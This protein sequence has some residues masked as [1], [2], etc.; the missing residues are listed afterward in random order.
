MEEEKKLP[1]N[2]RQMAEKEE[3]VRVYLEDYAYTFIHKLNCD[4]RVRTGV[5]LGNRMIAENKRCW[6]VKG[7]VELEDISDNE[8]A[9]DGMDLDEAENEKG[10]RR[11]KQENETI[12]QQIWDNTQTVIQKYFPGCSVCGWFI[13]G[14][15]E[16]FPDGEQLKRTHQRI[17]TGE[18]CLMY[19]KQGDEESFWME[20]DEAILHLKGYFVYYEKNE[21]MQNYMLSRHEEHSEA[22]SDQAALNFRKIMK[23]KQDEKHP[24]KHPKKHPVKKMPQ[25]QLWMKMGVAVAFLL[26]VGGSILFSRGIKKSG[27]DSVVA[28]AVGASVERQSGEVQKNRFV[29]GEAESESTSL[30]ENSNAASERIQAENETK[31]QTKQQQ[32]TQE[33]AQDL[34]QQQETQEKAQDLRQEQTQEEK[35]QSNTD[36]KDVAALEENGIFSGDMLFYKDGLGASVYRITGETGSA[37]STDVQKNGD[38]ANDENASSQGVNG[39]NLDSQA[40]SENTQEILPVEFPTL[41]TNDEET[42]NTASAEEAAVN[43]PAAYTVQP[44]DTLIEISKKFYGSSRMVMQIKE[45]NGLDD[46]NKIY[47]G[48]ELTLP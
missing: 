22:V 29:T 30:A 20:E 35:A 34:R 24:K 11:K 32:E 12:T 23:E 38:K 5:L 44:G 21:E 28:L 18:N 25:T 8:K 2:I 14:S 33:K 13:C 43:R 36:K 47:I 39:Q 48:Q 17:F 41:A 10:E 19:W 6:F 37:E 15:E 27:E 1:K 9:Q 42:A 3:R 26:L 46:I 45:A 7:A 31:T 40:A 16:N 4:G